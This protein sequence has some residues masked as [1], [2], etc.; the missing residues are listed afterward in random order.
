MDQIQRKKMFFKVRNT[1]LEMLKDRNY[2]INESEF[3]IGFDIFSAMY[4]ENKQDLVFNKNNDENKI[5]VHFYTESK[6]FGK[7][8]LTNILTIIDEKYGSDN[9]NI[10]IVLEDK[11]TSTIQKELEENHNIEI[12]FVKKLM[13]NITKHVL[14]PKHKLLNENEI[15]EI[16]DK[17]QCKKNQLPKIQYDDPVARYYGAKVGDVFEITRPTPTTGIFK[18]YRVVK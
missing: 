17:Y 13:F 12:F 18:V 4:S 8:E 6:N 1:I 15:K 16:L 5:Y 10:L 14:V 7:K 11:P 2:D 9:I 3:N